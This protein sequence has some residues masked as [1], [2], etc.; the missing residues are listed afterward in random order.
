MARP[1]RTPMQRERDLHVVADLYCQGWTQSRI[2]DKMGVTRPQ[3]GYD[4]R[5][6]QKRWQKSAL[7]RFDE[8]KAAELAKIDHLE[9]VA[10]E[11]WAC[12]FLH[13]M[14]TDTL[15]S[16]DRLWLDRTGG[17]ETGRNGA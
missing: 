3:I 6:I 12:S 17:H 1:K 8:R 11:A 14:A 7:S 10:F 15:T 9:K 5:I 16:L 4:L 2:A 13:R